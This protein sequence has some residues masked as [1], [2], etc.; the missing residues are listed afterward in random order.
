MP[1]QDNI[2]PQPETDSQ[3]NLATEAP[4]PSKLDAAEHAAQDR[5][6]V[7]KNQYKTSLG[8]TG[9]KAASD[10]IENLQDLTIIGAVR[11]AKGAISFGEFSKD[12]VS[13]LRGQLSDAFAYKTKTNLQTIYDA[14]KAHHDDTLTKHYG[15]PKLTS[16]ENAN[17]VS[18][19]P[20]A[21]PVQIAGQEK[22]QNFPLRFTLH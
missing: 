6:A 15:L 11:L 5:I 16:G 4:A 17:A 13:R 20:Q 8:S 7:R 18:E 3:S 19:E 21:N 9:G 22:S 2:V 12:F 1:L 10:A 14:A